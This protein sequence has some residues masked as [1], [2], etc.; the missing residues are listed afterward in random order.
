MLS[1]STVAEEEALARDFLGS[2]DLPEEPAPLNE[3]RRDLF[4][5]CICSSEMVSPEPEL[6]E[7]RVSWEPCL[8]WV[9][10]RVTEISGTGTGRAD[11]G[12]M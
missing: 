9:G 6:E 3:V 8:G 5:V 11:I 1:E 4:F 10:D 7:D 12:K 2:A